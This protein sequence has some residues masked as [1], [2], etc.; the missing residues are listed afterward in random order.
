[1][2]RRR[3]MM[4]VLGGGAT[5]VTLY[6]SLIGFWP[7]NEA[8]GNM[9]DAHTNGLTLTQHADPTFTTG[10]V[11]PTARNL[12]EASSQCFDRA[13]ETLL[14]AGTGA[15]TIA[16]W[17]NTDNVGQDFVAKTAGEFLLYM[18]GGQVGF[19]VQKNGGGSASLLMSTDT[20]LTPN[21]P[22]FLAAWYDPTAGRIYEQINNGLPQSVACA[23]YIVNST[24]A[25]SIGKAVAFGAANGIISPVMMWKKV[26]SNVE[27]T[28]L[29]NNGSG[30]QYPA[31]ANVVLDEEEAFTITPTASLQDNVYSQDFTN[32]YK[33]NTFSRLKIN[34]DATFCL[35]TVYSNI[36]T[37]RDVGVY[38]NGTYITTLRCAATGTHNFVVNIPDGN[39]ELVVGPQSPSAGLFAA[40]TFIKSVTLY[41][42]EPHT[43]TLIAPET[44]A[45][46]VLVYGDSI[47]NGW[48]SDYPVKDAWSMILRQYVPVIV[49]AFSARAL[50]YE[51]S[52]DTKRATLVSSLA[53]GNPSSVWLSIGTN[54]TA[55]WTAANFGIAYA[56]LLDKLHAALP[57]A[58]I[59]AQSPI[60]R[61]TEGTLPDFRT[62]IQTACST[63]AWSTYIDGTGATFPQVGDLSDGLHPTTAGHIIYADAVKTILG[64]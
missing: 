51:G 53:A 50:F 2:D 52:D 24:G 57:S 32:F 5:P 34:T 4:T 28:W 13:S 17:I 58:A 48:S 11:Y 1:M 43:S 22:Y 38:S 6:D 27:R 36:S 61:G 12:V 26:L 30:R 18:N 10:I 59:Y 40:G 55:L 8:S 7:G 62:E 39:L 45:T 42:A 49:D 15:L 31:L 9:L 21:T 60:I 33:C 63:R 16:C 41:G 35:V 29:Y 46:R 19:L 44:P 37:Y 54:D 3:M 20:I 56:D 25:F 64:V 14:Q 23:A 47:A